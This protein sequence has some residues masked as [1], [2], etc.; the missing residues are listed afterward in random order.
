MFKSFLTEK[1][2]EIVS[3]PE[4]YLPESLEQ[5]LWVLLKRGVKIDQDILETLVPL[6]PDRSALNRN[7]RYGTIG[8]GTYLVLGGIM[9]FMNLFSLDGL[10][11]YGCSV[12]LLRQFN[13]T[14][15]NRWYLSWSCRFFLSS[16]PLCKF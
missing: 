14:Q 12:F 11:W 3:K 10:S 16:I 2:I 1:L 9:S 15:K 4:S 7:F 13:V 6:L 8:L 5:S